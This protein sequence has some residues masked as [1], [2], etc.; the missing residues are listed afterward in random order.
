MAI[1]ALA[2][3]PSMLSTASTAGSGILGAIGSAAGPIGSLV[4][5]IG[6]LF[7][8]SGNNFKGMRSQLELQSGQQRS[9]AEFYAKYLPEAQ[10]EGWARAGIHPLAGMGIPTH[11]GGSYSIGG[12]STGRDT[13]GAIS[14]MGQ[15]ISRAAG[16]FFTKEQ[17]SMEMAS[18][19]L[20]LENQ[21]LQNERL[22]SE[23]NMMNAPGT[24]PG[25]PS[26]S[27]VQKV[28]KQVT[29]NTGGG[30]E[31]G[32]NPG[33]TYT[34]VPGLGHVLLPTEKAAEQ[35]E[36]SYLIPLL[37]DLY[38]GGE[39]FSRNVTMPLRSKV[40]SVIKKLEKRSQYKPDY[41]IK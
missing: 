7:G 13:W 19:A 35:T 1:T 12:G 25:L 32:I 14:D 11:A 16:A 21:Q 26:E 30:I 36:A 22:R 39:Y 18:N 37:M 10:A 27:W 17:R 8:G 29:H 31:A 41:L 20:M 34:D 28:A 23:I 2:S 40:L 38:S 15:G 4:G 3:L 6:G 5:S 24:P 33:M 9:D